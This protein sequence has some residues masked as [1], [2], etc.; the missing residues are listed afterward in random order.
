VRPRIRRSSSAIMRS[1]RRLTLVICRAKRDADLTL[2]DRDVALARFNRGGPGG[3]T[4]QRAIANAQRS[5]KRSSF[6]QGSCPN[7]HLCPA[8]TTAHGICRYR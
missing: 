2:I 8:L 7:L 6:S 1:A 4:N 3:T 5:Q